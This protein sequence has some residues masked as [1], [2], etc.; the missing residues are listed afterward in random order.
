MPVFDHPNSFQTFFH[1]LPDLIRRNA[2]VLRTKPHIFF[3][4]SANDL[5]VRILKYHSR[6]LSYIPKFIRITR[7]LSIYPYGTFRWQQNCIQMLGKGRFSGTIMS[8][9]CYKLSFF[10]F[11]IYFI[12]STRCPNHIAF[13]IT[14]FI[15]IYQFF[16]L[17]HF[18]LSFSSA[19]YVLEIYI[20]R[21]DVS[22]R[23]MPDCYDSACL[24]L[25]G[26]CLPPFYAFSGS[27]YSVPIV[28]TVT[29]FIFCS[30]SGL[31]L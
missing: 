25:C 29:F 3:Y 17:D 22:D 24:Y 23:C 20:Q 18:H 19:S 5:I 27:G 8:E 11:N 4:Y 10:C 31:S 7:I 16:C 1:P 6:R 30:S 2:Q 12:N 26:Y 9:N 13:F 14:F 15:F 28:S 21:S